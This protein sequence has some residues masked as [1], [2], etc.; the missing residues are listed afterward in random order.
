MGPDT[1][2]SNS[3]DEHYDKWR[4]ESDLRTLTEAKLIEKDPTRMKHVKRC[5]KE[6]LAEMAEMKKY[7]EGAG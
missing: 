2:A 5:A 6:K 3:K 1:I 4:A 7:A